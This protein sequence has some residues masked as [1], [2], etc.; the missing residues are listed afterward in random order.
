MLKLGCLDKQSGL[1]G[2]QFTPPPLDLVAQCSAALALIVIF[3]LL[4]L[5]CQ[6]IHLI[7]KAQNCSFGL[8]PAV[9]QLGP[10]CQGVSTK[11]GLPPGRLPPSA[12]SFCLDERA[13]LPESGVQVSQLGS[14]TGHGLTPFTERL[15]NALVDLAAE[16]RVA[17]QRGQEG[18]DGLGLVCGGRFLFNG[19][20]HLV[21]P[22]SKVVDLFIEML[23]A[24]GQFAQLCPDDLPLPKA[25]HVVL[26]GLGSISG[27]LES[28]HIEGL[29]LL[30]KSQDADGRGQGFRRFR[31]FETADG[32]QNVAPC[33]PFENAVKGG[34]G[35]RCQEYALAAS[36]GLSNDL[37]DQ[38]RLPRTRR[39]LHEADV[40]G[41]NRL[42]HRF[43]LYGI[44][45]G[46]EK[47]HGA[48]TN[49]LQVLRFIRQQLFK[50][51]AFRT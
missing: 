24:S 32:K 19:R 18:R 46:I 13:Q 25:L 40:G 12:S 9:F 17:D 42:S 50:Q 2:V 15:V 6:P 21:A 1:L 47:F 26:D 48:G 38:A 30:G 49:R 20:G 41:V 16:L 27:C 34:A 14:A 51:S 10:P 11:G 5:A 3:G 45:L 44:Q 23:V 22:C 43:P 33:N 37:G 28:I 39:S 31:G 8:L 4:P 29:N 7:P 35:Q 36:S